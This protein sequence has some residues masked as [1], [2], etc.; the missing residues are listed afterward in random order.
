MLVAG[1]EEWV[2]AERWVGLGWDGAVA[3]HVR[4]CL[5]EQQQVAGY[6]VGPADE[7]LQAC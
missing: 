6:Y 3:G 2:V 7:W 1:A 5:Q 4:C